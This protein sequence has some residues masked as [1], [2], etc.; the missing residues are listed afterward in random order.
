M[1]QVGPND[2]SSPCGDLG[3][4]VEHNHMQILALFLVYL[5]CPPES[6]QAIQEQIL[7]QLTSHLD[8][9]KELLFREIREL[10]PQGLTLVREAE[11]EN[12]DIKSMILQLQQTEVDD[13]QARDDFFEDLMQ[14]VRVLFMTEE[15]DLL[16]LV[17]RCATVSHFSY[18]TAR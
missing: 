13:E 6:R 16:P 3:R 5:R 4:K 18:P 15:R 10:G 7:R 2:T 14:S 12:E 8:T 17:D 11:M 9:E 1:G